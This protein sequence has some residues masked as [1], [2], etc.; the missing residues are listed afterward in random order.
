MQ[1]I[2]KITLI[3]MFFGTFGTT[4]GGII[5]VCF[6][7]TS[8]KFLSFILSFAS[9]LMLAII[10]FDLIPEAMKIANILNV[11]IGISCGIIIMIICDIVVQNRF[12][13]KKIKT[14]NIRKLEK[15]LENKVGINSLLKT[16]IIV[17]IG[18]ALHNLPEGLA[19]G[20]GF[21]ASITLGYSLAVAICLH[22]IPE[23]NIDGNT[24]EKRWN[25]P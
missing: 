17:S 10:C 16:G 18:I 2:L 9:G 19:I 1:E 25:E 24:N 14:T 3:G 8:N 21:G 20:S 12:G 22:D 5:G 11:L 7:R 23:R 13:E 15:K 4:I 6:K